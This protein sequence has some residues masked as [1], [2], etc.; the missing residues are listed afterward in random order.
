MLM[1]D[2]RLIVLPLI[3][4]TLLSACS[5]DGGGGL[6]SSRDAATVSGVAHDAPLL[7][8]P[9]NVYAWDNGQKGDLLG[10][11]TTDDKGDYQIKITSADRPI[12]IEA[13]RGGRYIEE[14][15]GVQVTLT[16]NQYMIAVAQYRSGQ[17][18]TVQTT[19]L[20]TVAACY[21]DYLVS[22][23]NRVDESINL[24]NAKF[25]A[26]YGVE[27]IGDK[28]LDVT[29]PANTS[30]SLTDGHKYGF[31]TAGISEFMATEVSDANGLPAHSAS[32]LTS[33]NWSSVGCGDIKADG[34]LNGFGYAAD[35]RT[36]TDL[37]FGSYAITPQAYR[38]FPARRML[39][40]VN[41]P[42]NKT[43]LPVNGTMVSFANG[44]S[45]S[46]D[47]VF[48]GLA[49]DPVDNNGPVITSVSAPNT[50]FSGASNIEFLINDPVG[51]ESIQ[52]FI[53]NNYVGNG[54]I[55]S[56]QLSVNTQL[57][58]DGEHTVKVIATDIIGNTSIEEVV[59]RFWNV[60]PAITIDSEGRTDSTSYVM[61][62]TYN[63]YAATVDS[64]KIG[65][66]N[67]EINNEQNTWFA[68]LNLSNGLN[69]LTI[70]AT[71]TL[72]NISTLDSI[73]FVDLN[74]PRIVPDTTRVRYTTFE[75]LYNLCELGDLTLT[76]GNDTPVCLR[77]DRVSL[78]GASVNSNLPNL[79]YVVMTVRVSDP[80][81]AGVFTEIEN[82][83]AE[84]KYQQ[85]SVDIF[86]WKPLTT[87]GINTDIETFY[88]PLVTEFF[89]ADFH[90]T[91]ANTTHHIFIRVLDDV[92][93]SSEVEFKVKL[94]ILVPAISM[95]TSSNADEIFNTA[96]STRTSI[97]GS[98][99]R[100]ETKFENVTNGP[101]FIN[102]SPRIYGT[103]T[104]TTER[105]QRINKVRVIKTREL[106]IEGFSIPRATVYY[107]G[108]TASFIATP[109]IN[110]E[111]WQ[112]VPTESIYLRPPKSL[113]TAP[114]GEQ[115]CS[116]S[117]GARIPTTFIYMDGMNFNYTH[118]TLGSTW[119]CGMGIVGNGTVIYRDVW[120]LEHAGGDTVCPNGYPC[121]TSVLEE[122]I[123]NISPGEIDVTIDGAPA[124]IINGRY[125]V[126]V[127]KTVSISRKT[128]LPNILHSTDLV[129]LT[130]ELITDY[131]VY[132]LD[133]STNWYVDM[134]ID[135]QIAGSEDSSPNTITIGS[136]IDRTIQK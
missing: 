22:R 63:S 47:N 42:K 132:N 126:P 62:G 59:Y 69:D 122:T 49:A 5:S 105:S 114:N 16:S 97:D 130:P 35:G 53:D 28:P 65:D 98:I 6:P 91:P 30:F 92:G 123:Y 23:G 76:S 127:G 85:N 104:H 102:P 1:K 3:V 43:T 73:V 109:S 70:T 52:F 54:Q 20:S 24:A 8:A 10:S 41:S 83:T 45:T 103:A 106:N 21:A 88:L 112:S 117:N 71:D 33:I 56:P 120:S 50:A 74:L 96:F 86:D 80:T 64:I 32:Y 60:G 75:G 135:L 34:L 7:G 15:S 107:N 129:V 125:V 108:A 72:G 113:M 67:A 4:A 19:P 101:V 13:G 17:P 124:Q 89:G 36:L 118:P 116:I 133:F 115:Y 27:V 128:T 9:V 38:T 44:L 95:N 79:E 55:E 46:T 119:G 25:S 51:V 94:D 61:T 131:R 66:I 100:E 11:T 99:L 121:N 14:A 134:R 58:V 81:G 18:I 77:S 90:Q 26:I 40:F 78:N 111:G 136:I 2:L 82:L 57:Y 110:Y 37:S 48:D 29:D 93:N 31:I 84:Y 39:T 87:R 68:N 12:L